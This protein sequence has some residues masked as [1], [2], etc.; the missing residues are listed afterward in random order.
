MAMRT[1]GGTRMIRLSSANCWRAGGM[2]N[3]WLRLCLLAE[4]HRVKQQRIYKL[5][6]MSHHVPLC[7]IDW[8]PHVLGLI[9]GQGSLVLT[10]LQDIGDSSSSSTSNSSSKVK[11]NCAQTCHHPTACPPPTLPR[12]TQRCKDTTTCVSALCQADSCCFCAAWLHWSPQCWRLPQ[13]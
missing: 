2:P 10:D 6:C 13:T 8:L 11:C 4:S 5:L 7:L 1:R 12:H 9:V 3:A